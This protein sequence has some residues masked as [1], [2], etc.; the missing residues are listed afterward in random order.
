MATIYEIGVYILFLLTAQWLALADH[1][2]LAEDMFRATKHVLRSDAF[3]S[4]QRTEEMYDW[5]NNT[6]VRVL[7]WEQQNERFVRGNLGLRL[8][9][10]QV[11]QVRAKE[12]SCHWQDFVDE[13]C[14]SN[15]NWEEGNF[16]VGW[17]NFSNGSEANSW[18]Y[19]KNEN[20]TRAVVFEFSLYNAN[21]N[22]FQT[23][24]FVIEFLPSG[25]LFPRFQIE[26]VQLS[27]YATPWDYIKLVME[28]LFGF[29]TL[30]MTFS[31]INEIRK[32]RR[33]FWADL[34]S[35]FDLV[36]LCLSYSVLAI[37]I[38][39]TVLKLLR[40][41]RRLT[42]LS[43]VL[44]QT[45]FEVLSFISIFTIFVTAFAFVATVTLGRSQ[46]FQSL[47]KTFSTLLQTSLGLFNH[48]SWIEGGSAALAAAIFVS[49]TLDLWLLSNGLH[50]SAECVASCVV[51]ARSRQPPSCFAS[52]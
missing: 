44:R 49:Y 37:D 39:R 6:L 46:E 50:V 23:A 14:Y 45:F 34:W 31:M 7:F 19:Q 22:L 4:I 48:L 25:G 42:M 15:S 17:S 3:Q 28:V 40:F 13:P 20:G 2:S 41:N 26:T 16:D 47:S 36:V 21:V 11:R 52:I 43:E 29:Y 18:K 10:A 38:Y 12:K 35:W 32:R 8:S 24:Q 27:R 9:G 5:A 30:G 33:S 51:Y 1:S